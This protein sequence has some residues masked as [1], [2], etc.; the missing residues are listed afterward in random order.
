[1]LFFSEYRFGV[2]NGAHCVAGIEVRMDHIGIALGKYLSL[3][4][5]YAVIT[6]R[7]LARMIKE[8]GIDFVNL[9]DEQF[10]E[11]LGDS[12]GAAAIFL[13]LIHI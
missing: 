9:P 4:H 12:T 11:V 3:I 6:T 1:M 5:I 8:A 10:D 7:E 13:S 2:S